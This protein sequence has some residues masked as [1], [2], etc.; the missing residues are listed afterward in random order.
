MKLG[1]GSVEEKVRHFR[2]TTSG[3][4][5]ACVGTR[6][7]GVGANKNGGGCGVSCVGK[8]GASHGRDRELGGLVR[9]GRKRNAPRDPEKKN[10][11]PGDSSEPKQPPT[12]FWI[13]FS[14]SFLILPSLFFF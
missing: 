9:P 8:H 10:S 5:A 14:L 6:R 11:A 4:N 13:L 3:G 7:A 12:P 2:R 1:W